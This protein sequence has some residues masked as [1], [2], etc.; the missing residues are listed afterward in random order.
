MMKESTKESNLKFWLSLCDNESASF[1]E[2]N[3][4]MLIK[5]VET[6]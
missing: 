1:I 5:M 6:R 2:M 3:S 4:D